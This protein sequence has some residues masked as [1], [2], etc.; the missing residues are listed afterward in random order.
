MAED[1]RRKEAERL[2]RLARAQWP[3]PHA[4]DLDG[5]GPFE[6]PLCGHV[7]SLGRGSDPQFVLFLET[8]KKS[9]EVRIP[10][11]SGQ[12]PGLKAL[13]DGLYAQYVASVTR[14]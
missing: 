7:S 1:D 14:Q 9:Q 4:I 2:Q 10:I 5:P 11:L 12:L 6:L 13:I 8:T 3:Q